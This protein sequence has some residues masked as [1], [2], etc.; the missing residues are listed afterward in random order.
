MGQEA[1]VTTP[2]Q[3]TRRRLWLIRLSIAFFGAVF[4]AAGLEVAGRLYIWYKHGVP[5]KS[6]GLWQHDSELGAIHANNSYSTH[7]Q[8]NNFGFRGRED[9]VEPKPAGSHRVICYGGSMCFCYNLPDGETWPE[10]LQEQLS[11][12]PGHAGD[13]VLNGGHISWA[14]GHLYRQAQRDV[15]RLKPDFVVFYSGVNEFTNAQYLIWSGRDFDQMIKDEQFGVIAM[16]LDQ[17]RWFKRNSVLARFIDYRIMGHV[18]SL[19][20]RI[21]PDVHVHIEDL[22]KNRTDAEFEATWPWKNYRFE[23]TRFV[24]L[25]REHGGTP[26]FVIEA[27][28]PD[29]ERGKRSYV[30]RYSAQAADV[31]RQAGVSVCDPRSALLSRSNRQDLFISSGV[32]VTAEGAKILADQIYQTI[33]GLNVKKTATSRPA[34]VSTRDARSE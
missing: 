32:H 15:P 21:S 27:G 31:M 18:R 23:L 2:P 8:T 13:Q 10:R 26:I 16:N 5:G 12:R 28:L 24:D 25:I 14:T 1:K 9:V 33:E 22:K 34:A 11:A 29:D 6:Y 3:L 19:H 7:T 4:V 17:N 30:L 20:H